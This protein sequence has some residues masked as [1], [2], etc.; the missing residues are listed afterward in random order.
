[1]AVFVRIRAAPDSIEVGTEHA[2][3]A[4]A[5]DGTG[6][7][8]PG[9][10][11]TWT[12]FDTA[13]ARVVMSGAT[14]VVRGIA[15]GRTTLTAAAGDRIAQSAVVVTWPVVT[16]E[17]T[18]GA[19][20]LWPGD[21][22]WL[23][24]TG[25]NA[26]GAQV[27][28]TT[29]PVAWTSS[30]PDVVEVTS[31]GGL[32]ARAL[33]LATITGAVF[34]RSVTTP[35]RV[36]GAASETFTIDVRYVGEVPV[37]VRR[38]MERAV[39]RWRQVIAA[40]LGT[41]QIVRSSCGGT[42]PAPPSSV[43]NL[44]VYVRMADV[45]AAAR[46]GPCITRERDGRLTTAV[47]VIEVHQGAEPIPEDADLAGLLIHELGHVLGIGVNWWWNLPGQAPLAHGHEVGADPVF[48][49]SAARRAFLAAG[50]GRYAGPAVPLARDLAHWRP[51]VFGRE[52]MGPVWDPGQLYPLS[53]VTL[54][55]LED[56]GYVV[57]YDAA[58]AYALP[59]LES[60]EQL[61]EMSSWRGASDRA[62]RDVIEMTRALERGGEDWHLHH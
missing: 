20:M 41:T 14:R 59:A 26:G 2:I 1:M 57:R 54:G 42:W 38:N 39:R 17:L 51:S 5:L 8:V 43:D 48:T 60:S 37:V 11:I 7:P 35:V 62:P 10:V 56:L 47:G 49:G 24:A 46:G 3:A 32:R 55:A 6:Q 36:L 50:G 53:A 27:R 34:G 40:P 31:T 16:L 21:T 18:T 61:Q 44:V 19:L 28:L 4:E 30:A 29:T 52:A 22:S 12:V 33:G 9:S 25:R 58:D 45:G 13:I 15:P 23:R